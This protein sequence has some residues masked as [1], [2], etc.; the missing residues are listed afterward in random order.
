MKG[1]RNYLVWAGIC[2]L[3]V[4]L[5]AFAVLKLHNA[6]LRFTAE[7]PA[8]DFLELPRT[9]NDPASFYFSPQPGWIKQP[10][11]T[12]QGTGSLGSPIIGVIEIVGSSGR[13]TALSFVV[14]TNLASVSAGHTV[15]PLACF[16]GK[17]RVDLAPLLT[18]GE[19]YT[20]V[21]RDHSS[22][23]DS[24]GLAMA[25]VHTNSHGRQTDGK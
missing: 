5:L 12:L 20:F 25:V 15:L 19:P 16:A 10:Y 8:L 21:L 1:F 9:T 7:T 24:I 6:V 11:L 14:E 13:T 17:S 23:L 2:V 18:P 4:A 3:V 22:I